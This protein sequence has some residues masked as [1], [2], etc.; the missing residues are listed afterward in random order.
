MVTDI[1]HS[2]KGQSAGLAHAHQLL[3]QGEYEAALHQFAQVPEAGQ[4]ADCLVSQAVCTIHLG[5]AQAALQFCDRALELNS[6]H[7]Q[8]WLFKGVALHRLGHY[9]EA[10]TCYDRAV[11]EQR[12]DGSGAQ[13][14]L[15]RGHLQGGHSF[16]RQ[17]KN[18][19]LL[20]RLWVN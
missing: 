19:N 3:E 6:H 12:P 1:P 14:A 20:R 9:G 18:I 16:L 2:P 11:G 7:P 15:N 17:L 13:A 8:A 4:D 5:R 10:Y